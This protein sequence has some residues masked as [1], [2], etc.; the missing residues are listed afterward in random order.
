MSPHDDVVKFLPADRGAMTMAGLPADS[1]LRGVRRSEKSGP[2]LW[3]RRAAVVL[4]AVVVGA[5]GLGFLGVRST[6]VS[7]S[8][9][10]YTLTVT[11]AAVARAGL[12][13][14]FHVE[15]SNADGL[16]QDITLR[17]NARYFD[18]FETQGFHPE[19]SEETS[20]GDVIALTFDPPD[21]G[22][23]F[24]LD[25]DAYIQ[26]SSQFGSDGRVEMAVGEQTITA[27]DFHTMLWP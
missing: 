10:G 11:Y 1:T 22:P 17:I 26:P 9:D 14:P 27:V 4:M 5:A 23:L 24:A 20:E 12:D 7:S 21:G 13:V 15:V 2:A 25:Y 16:T 19:P 3:G 18:I 6:E 8:A